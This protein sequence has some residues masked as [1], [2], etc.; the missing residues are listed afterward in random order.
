MRRATLARVVAIA[1]N[2]TMVKVDKMAL[3]DEVGPL[4]GLEVV[5]R[6][7]WPSV[8]WP[9]TGRGRSVSV[10]KVLGVVW[11]RLGRLEV[12]RREAKVKLTSGWTRRK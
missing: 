11:V 4:K 1:R 9:C 8:Q 7:Q 5:K 2:E 12:D 6:R 3:G 10:S